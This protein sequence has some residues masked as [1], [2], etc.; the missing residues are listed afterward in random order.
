MI[1]IIVNQVKNIDNCCFWST[2]LCGSLVLFPWFFLC[3][4]WWK[5]RVNK[6]YHVDNQGYDALT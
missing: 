4:D 5:R 2:I 6:L 3:C 1:S